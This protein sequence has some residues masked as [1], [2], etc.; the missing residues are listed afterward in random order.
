MR[1]LS[2]AAVSA[3]AVFAAAPAEAQS[4]RELLVSAAFHARDKGTAL[5]R[6][7]AAMKAADAI[8]ARRPNDHEARLQK[9]VALSYRGKLKRSRSDILAARRAFEALV[10]ASPR[11]AEAQMA[12]AGWHLGAVI[13]LG[14]VVART[15][16]GARKGHG[17]QALERALK[18]GGGRAFFP[19]FASLNRIQLD[20]GNIGAARALA[21][22]AVKGKAVSSIDRIMQSRAAALLRALGSGNGKAAA[23]AADDLLPFGRL[24]D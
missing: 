8:L 5:A 22:A 13:E 19:G 7:D 23:K 3:F 16:L 20:P 6:I 24:R 17:M 18:L 10:A 12:L 21:E 11:D 14:P 4:P 2:L 9:G 1:Y 15:A